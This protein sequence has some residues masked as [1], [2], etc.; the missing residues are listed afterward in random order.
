M[1]I[2]PWTYRIR[3]N[4]VCLKMYVIKQNLLNFRPQDFQ[5]KINTSEGKMEGLCGEQSN[6]P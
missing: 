4:S 5:N 3:I 6:G 1:T 2:E